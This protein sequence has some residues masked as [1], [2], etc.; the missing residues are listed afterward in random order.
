MLLVSGC[1]GNHF[2]R[3]AK[4]FSR[5]ICICLQ[6]SCKND[7]P[8]PPQR[9]L[10]VAT[11]PHRMA[12]GLAAHGG[13]RGPPR[14][15]TTQQAPFQAAAR[16]VWHASGGR[17]A[18]PPHTR[19]ENSCGTT[20]CAAG[21][22][23]QQPPAASPPPAP[24]ATGPHDAHGNTTRHP[25]AAPKWPRTRARNASFA[26]KICQCCT[27]VVILCRKYNII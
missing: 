1:K 3:N 18:S 20:R 23:A 22:R 11:A 13:A 26:R 8:A 7:A 25:R 16:P 10:T 27:F 6:K 19:A 4:T 15:K 17:F 21:G 5:K 24:P 12:A 9:L 2:F 14:R